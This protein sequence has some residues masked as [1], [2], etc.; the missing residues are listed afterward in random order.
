MKGACSV[1]IIITMKVAIVGYG[2]MGREVEA[3]L[4]RRGHTVAVRVDATKEAGAD[5][6]ELTADTLNGA[7]VAIEFSLPTAVRA[8]VER[9]GKL[10]VSAVVGTTGWES[11]RQAVREIVGKSGIGLVTGTNFS[12]GAHIF[13]S[14]VSRAASLIEQI[15]DYDIFAYEIHHNQKK[16]SPS[17]TALTMA[18]RI[19]SAN[20]RKKRIQTETVHGQIEPD[21]L[22]VASVRGGAVPGIHTVMIDSPADTI[23]I[24][25]TA[26]N[27]GGFALGAVMAAEWLGGKVGYFTVEDFTRDLMSEETR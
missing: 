2:R 7:E 21:A 11:D 26:R 20:N 19:L 25:H 27:R 18:E 23:E 1:R 10:G 24:R 14:I 6:T 4:D 5:C 8:N 9:Y 22:H 3:V 16:D 17:G 12:I 15:D 13:L